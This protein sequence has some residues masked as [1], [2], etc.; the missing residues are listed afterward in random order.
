MEFFLNSASMAMDKPFLDMTETWVYNIDKTA[1]KSQILDRIN[2]SVIEEM[3]K[4][5]GAKTLS[6]VAFFLPPWKSLPPKG[7]KY[8][9][10]WNEL[11]HGNKSYEKL[12]A[13]CR[14]IVCRN[15]KS[16]Y[17]LVFSP[18][19]AVNPEFIAFLKGEQP[20]V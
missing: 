2:S 14:I 12:I 1:L 20:T 8:D 6:D 4:C 16:S 17:V 10:L 13:G 9:I 11:R 7:A 15:V 3:L 18:A 5:L 19:A